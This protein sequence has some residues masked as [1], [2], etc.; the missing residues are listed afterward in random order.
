M[1]KEGQRTREIWRKGRGMETD[2]D[3][4]RKS[5]GM[6]GNEGRK[7]FTWRKK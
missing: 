4:N 1:G 5:V 7:I 2:A 3:G 6:E